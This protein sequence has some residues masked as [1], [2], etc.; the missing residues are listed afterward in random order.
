MIPKGERGTTGIIMDW[1]V[2]FSVF[3]MFVSFASEVD[4]SSYPAYLGF[5]IQHLLLDFTHFLRS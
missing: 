1:H 3:E 5:L 2:F 4:D